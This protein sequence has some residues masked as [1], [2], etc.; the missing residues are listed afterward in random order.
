MLLT[1]LKASLVLAIAQLLVAALRNLSAATKHLLLTTGMAAFVVMPLVA[2]FAPAW[3]I[4]YETAR[5]AGVPAGRSV[6]V[7]AGHEPIGDR[8]TARAEAGAPVI[9]WGV[10][11][12]ALLARLAFS[13]WRLRAIVK[14]AS[15]P[16]Q[17]ILDLV[18]AHRVRVLLSDR[19]H[20]PMVWGLRT[21]TLLL[22]GAAE[23]WSD[24]ELRATLV[25][26][27]GHLQ[28]LDYLSLA[29]LNVVAALLWFHPQVWLARRRALAEGERACDDLV[30]RAGA[31]ASTYASHLLHVARLAPH[32]EPLGAF[33]AMSR[34]SQLE[35]RMLAILSPSTNRQTIGG[36]RL[37]F[38]IA[39]FLA[40][41]VPLSVMQ[42]SAQPAPPAPPQAP[43]ALA[44]APAPRAIA[45]TAPFVAPAPAPS[46]PPA[47]APASLR[48][49]APTPPALPE[50][51]SFA[52]IAMTPAPA[53]PVAMPAPAAVPAPAAI[54]APAPA[55]PVSVTPAAAPVPSSPPAPPAPPADEIL[56]VT[57]ADLAARPHRLLG[58]IEGRG[59][60]LKL[61]RPVNTGDPSR[62]RAEV[63]AMRR[64]AAKA[65]GKNANAIAN[66][67][68]AREI[69]I[70]LPL[71]SAAV[72][73][74]AQAVLFE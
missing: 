74:A 26:E 53:A 23:E 54:P 30:L 46:R 22:P 51:P 68:C 28:R 8:R 55:A 59:Y 52:P 18:G 60:T 16:S 21:G 70:G 63:I 33:L 37:M 45:G 32:R 12:C 19:V 14:S 57:D 62:N 38:A 10:V 2:Y 27:L 36:K 15:A 31:R 72:V 6:D 1:L 71:P 50:P 9:V 49:K 20:V 61:H 58:K 39:T 56:V 35:G 43:K 7:L 48:A 67:K 42:I 41:V 66:V 44:S 24:E 64:L 40:V 4:T 34:P 29:L 65:A 3:T 17:R 73:C 25:H 69:S 5:S 47:P 11:A 13:A